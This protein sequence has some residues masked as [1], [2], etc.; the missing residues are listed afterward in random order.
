M[1]DVINLGMVSMKEIV[2][3]AYELASSPGVV[4]FSPSATSFDMFKDYKDRDEQ[5]KKAVNSLE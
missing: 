4:L 1:N 3:A 2:K 5:F